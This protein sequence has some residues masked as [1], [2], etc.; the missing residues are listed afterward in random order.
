MSQSLLDR[1]GFESAWSALGGVT[2]GAFDE[3]IERHSE[4]HRAYH[5]PRHLRE[6][7]DWSWRV[8]VEAD[9]RSR[10]QVAIYFHDLIYD[11]LARDNEARSADRFCLLAR[12]AE[13]REAEIGLVRDLILG[14]ATHLAESVEGSWMNDIDLS[15]LGASPTRFAEFEAAIRHEYAAV[16]PDVYRRG[17]AHVLRSF[18][19][20]DFVYQTVFFRERLE[21]LAR[22]NLGRAVAEL[23][24]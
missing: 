22:D 3:V 24:A 13:L 16:E 12:D 11:P 9:T 7:L 10:L 19:E 17:R 23:C 6:C 4:P 1:E 5:G 2:F 15:I 14:T 8:P 18:L 20:R 21:R